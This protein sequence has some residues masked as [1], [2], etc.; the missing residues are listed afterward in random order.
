MDRRFE[1]EYRAVYSE[2]FP[3]EDGHDPDFDE[4]ALSFA[5]AVMNGLAFER[6]TGAEYQ[7]PVNDYL[8]TLKAMA[9]VFQPS[10]AAGR[11]QP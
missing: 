5:F 10:T 1:E 9:T 11:N 2:L 3:N 6:L 4:M 7:R 8:E